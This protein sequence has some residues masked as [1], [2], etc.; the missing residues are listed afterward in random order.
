MGSNKGDP[1]YTS[2]YNKCKRG[3]N[4]GPQSKVKRT[5]IK[6]GKAKKLIKRKME[7][8]EN[9]SM[10]REFTKKLETGK[11]PSSESLIYV[12]TSYNTES[13]NVPLIDLTNDNQQLETLYFNKRN[14]TRRLQLRKSLATTSL[15]NLP[16][17]RKIVP[18]KL[19]STSTLTKPNN[20]LHMLDIPSPFLN[21]EDLI[22]NY[23]S[24]FWNKCNLTERDNNLIQCL[25]Q[26]E[27]EPIDIID[28]FSPTY[29]FNNSINLSLE[30][31]M[32]SY[33]VS[34]ND[35]FN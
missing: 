24:N 3:K 21:N 14:F 11:I 25:L 15:I 2:T 20:K 31:L 19:N 18:E 29:P 1:K 17:V 22:F 9:E 35:N 34:S 33:K 4:M 26:Q 30:G 27:N 7:Y 6:K 5:R 23:D 10:Y 28:N 8:S 12:G 16:T 13:K 32:D